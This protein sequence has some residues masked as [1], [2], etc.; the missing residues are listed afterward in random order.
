MTDLLQV[1]SVDTAALPCDTRNEILALCRAAY[2]EDL[3]GYLGKVGPGLHLLGRVAG[4]VMSHA[5]VVERWLEV[6]GGR[7]LRTAYVELVATRP[8]QQR[9]DYAAALMRRLAQE[10]G[11]FDIGG[12]SPTDQRFY[13]RLGWELWRGPLFVRNDTKVEPTADEQLMVLRLPRTPPDLSL[14]EPVSI[15]WRRGEVW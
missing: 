4:A 7:R 6:A 15:E 3:T 1:T 2:D 9:R 11:E 8:D 5:M 13:A 14:D 12:L 10:I